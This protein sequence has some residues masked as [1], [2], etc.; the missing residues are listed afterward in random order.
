MPVRIA[1]C[2]RVAALAYAFPR[3]PG[4]KFTES[5]QTVNFVNF[6]SPPD[7]RAGKFF[8][9]WDAETRACPEPVEG[10]LPRPS[11]FQK[12]RGTVRMAAGRSILPVSASAASTKAASK[13]R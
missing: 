10:K 12:L 3:R 1:P 6:A 9:P 2:V 13:A 4:R 7:A 8:A 11:T 5:R